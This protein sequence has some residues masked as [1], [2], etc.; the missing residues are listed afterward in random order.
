MTFDFVVDDQ[1][2]RRFLEASPISND[3]ETAA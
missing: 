1:D 2:L 3:L